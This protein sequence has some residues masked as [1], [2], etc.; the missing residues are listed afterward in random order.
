MASRIDYKL[1]LRRIDPDSRLFLQGMRRLGFRREDA[2]L[3]YQN[4]RGPNSR[5]AL[6]R[7]IADKS[8][9][10][11]INPKDVSIVLNS[12][13]KTQA[14]AVKPVKLPLMRRVGGRLR[15]TPQRPR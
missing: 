8:H 12:I 4:R 14:R 13:R 6:V 2:Q 3:L 9:S 11:L 7:Q 1:N 5:I 10:G 15:R